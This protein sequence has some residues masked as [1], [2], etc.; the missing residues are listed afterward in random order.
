MVAPTGV[1]GGADPE[2]AETGT[3]G[4]EAGTAGEEAAETGAAGTELPEAGRAGEE[5]AEP[6]EARP[7]RD[8]SPLAIVG[9]IFALIA[10][11]GIA[12]GVLAV[13]THGFHRKTVTTYRPPPAVF[14]LRPG[15]CL[16]SGANGLAF[17]LLPCGKPHDAEVFATFTLTGSSW[18]GS[19]AVKQDAGL[20]CASRLSG[21]LNPQLANVG[22]AQEYVYPN[23]SAWQAGERTVVCEVSS[24]TG[25]LTGPVRNPG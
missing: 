15:D 6:A 25:P 4:E 16:N 9:L 17:T 12:A 21:Y 7:G 13:A 10:L 24:S 14:K 8:I 5:G 3:A 18:P 2:P 1:A 23:Q 22:L 19:A 11:V 20:G